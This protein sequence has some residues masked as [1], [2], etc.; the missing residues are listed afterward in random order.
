MSA[1]GSLMACHECDLLHRMV[2]VPEGG[3]VL[4]SRCGAVLLRNKRN[5]LDRT[6]AFTLT[7]LVLFGVS[8]AF[9]FL[10]FRLQGIVQDTLLFSGI[11]QLY[12]QG[13]KPLALL[14]AFTTLLAP[15]AQLAGLLY[16]LVP[17]RFKRKA[18]GV[19]RVFKL[20][21][22]LLPWS[23]LEV[24]MLGILVSIVKLAKMAT[25]V[26]GIA[27]FSFAG[28]IVALTAAINSLDPH[29][30]WDTWEGER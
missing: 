17:L 21:R 6:L 7:S 25:I 20:L 10:G 30:V 26:P 4:C 8:N 12:D 23:M 15:G 9:P 3:T 27:A 16:V 11:L 24:F 22:S 14:V 1:A 18:P 29:E 13:M 19:F 28:L 2:L 5:S